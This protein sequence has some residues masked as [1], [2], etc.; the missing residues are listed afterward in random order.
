MQICRLLG[1]A[2]GSTFRF[3]RSRANQFLLRVQSTEARDSRAELFADR[4]WFHPDIIKRLKIHGLIRPT[5]IQAAAIPRLLGGDDVIMAAET[6]SGKTLTYLLPLIQRLAFDEPSRTPY[7]A[8]VLVPNKELIAQFLQVASDFGDNLGAWKQAACDVKSN[9]SAPIAVGTPESIL[10]FTSGDSFDDTK[11]VVA[12]EADM[13][14]VGSFQAQTQ[15]ILK[16]LCKGE[17]RRQLAFSMATVPD[18][19]TLSVDAWLRKYYPQCQRVETDL[20]HCAVPQLQQNWVE[21]QGGPAHRA[22]ADEALVRAL[23]DN[24]GVAT[25]VFVNTQAEAGRI[26][27]MLRRN[28]IFGVTEYHKGISVEERARTAT[29]LRSNK[30]ECIAVCTSLASRGLDTLQVKH[31]IQRDLAESAVD[32]L[33]RIGRTARAGN[34]G[35]V[36]NIIPSGE[37]LLADS[38]RSSADGSVDGSFSRRRGLRFRHKKMLRR[39]AEEADMLQEGTEVDV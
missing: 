8:L 15:R 25:M 9:I 28:A 14:L 20:L 10:K 35:M 19:G 4:S 18:S 33:H 7:R 26:A 11:I 3:T 29:R 6:G 32:H 37:H 1:S 13:L 24:E 12:D 27:T 31:V 23:K 21:V 38:L 2:R 39:A 34:G 17:H 30:G 5:D 16:H 22:A 36:T